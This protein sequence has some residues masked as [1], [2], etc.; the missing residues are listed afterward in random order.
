MKNVGVVA[1]GMVLL[2]GS[3][4]F[5]ARSAHEPSRMAAGFSGDPVPVCGPKPCGNGELP[6]NR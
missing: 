6:Q 1:F 2:V 5:S 3:F 4:A